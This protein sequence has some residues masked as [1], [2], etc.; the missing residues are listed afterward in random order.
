VVSAIQAQTLSPKLLEKAKKNA[1]LE[2]KNLPPK[3]WKVNRPDM[4]FEDMMN[5]AWK[6]KFSMFNDDTPLHVYTFGNGSAKTAEDAFNKASSKAQAQLPG[7]TL[8]Y[9]TTWNMAAEISD[10]EKSKIEAAINDAEKNINNTLTDLGIDPFVNMIREK[11][12]KITVH[13]RYYYPQMEVR[14]ITRKLI[15]KELEKTTDWSSEKMT[16]LL[17]YEK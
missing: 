7:L 11:G 13:L 10:D 16:K 12:S 3:G 9:F 8:L 5:K 17:T 14:E 4:S 1:A 2:I 15:M 6:L